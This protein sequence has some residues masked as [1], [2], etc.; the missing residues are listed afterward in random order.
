VKTRLL[1]FIAYRLFKHFPE[2][3]AIMTIF[4]LKGAYNHFAMYEED[5]EV[6]LLVAADTKLLLTLLEQ[7]AL[8]IQSTSFEEAAQ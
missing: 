6:L 3:A 2:M 4:Y 1:H 7:G 5:D 8:P